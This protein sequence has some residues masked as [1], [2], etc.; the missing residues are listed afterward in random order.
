M[1]MDL[2]DLNSL[3]SNFG[4]HRSFSICLLLR[5][6]NL[7]QLFQTASLKLIGLYRSPSLP[8]NIWR[9]ELASLLEASTG[10]GESVFLLGDLNC[11]LLC[12]DKPPKNGRDLLDI[13][14]LFHFKNLVSSPTRETAKTS[15]LLDLVLTNAKTKILTTGVVNPHISDHSLVFAIL[16]ASPPRSRSQKITF[17]SLKNFS[18]ESFLTDLNT[19]PFGTVM[20]VFDDVNDKLYAFE[21]LFN[22]VV[23][24]HAPPKQVHLRGNQVP[25]LTDDW[26]KAIRHRNHLWKAFTRDRTDAN[27][28]LY[29]SQRNKCTSLRRKAIVSYFKRKSIAVNQDPKQFWTTFQPFLH[30]SKSYKPNNVILQEE[31]KMITDKKQIAS[32][33]N[34]Y[35][36]NLASDIAE[37]VD[38]TGDF[39]DHPSVRAILENDMDRTDFGFSPISTIISTIY[40][41]QLLKEIKVNKSSGYD[42]ITPRLLKESA[43]VLC[44]PLCSIFNA[45]IAQCN[46]PKNWKKGQVTP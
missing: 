16:R 43:S 14:D 25:Y 37:P 35:F 34:D 46:Y 32:I 38:S 36:V 40:I 9:K 13:M 27:Y 23:N 19:V 8:K 18:T 17:R 1:S 21:S 28:L 10:K 45:S 33:F 24:K 11:D 4:F 30:T 42:H 2:R 12:P 15:T 6:R 39:Q 7:I 3:M 26:R 20:S 44:F 31:N 29:K 41:E 5:K 22:D